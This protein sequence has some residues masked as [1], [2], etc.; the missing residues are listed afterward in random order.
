MSG[1]GENSEN[2][3]LDTPGVVDAF[4][5]VDLPDIDEGTLEEA[6]V[7]LED[8]VTNYA[9]RFGIIGAGQGGGRIAS[10][11]WN[12][13]IGNRARRVIDRAQSIKSEPLST[14][15]PSRLD[16][17]PSHRAPTAPT[18]QIERMSGKLCRPR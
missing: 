5:M 6:A 11:F 17:K 10:T 16:R 2:G 14:K 1:N 7:N 12:R 4:D 3:E 8:D 9:V 18:P 15:A 13:A